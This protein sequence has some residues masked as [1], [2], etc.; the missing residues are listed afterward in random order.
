MHK[1][2][3]LVGIIGLSTFLLA[4]SGCRDD[5]SYSAGG[6]GPNPT[7]PNAPPNT[8]LMANAAFSPI[9]LTVSKNTIVTWTNNDGIVHTATSD[10]GAW[11]T[12][13][14]PPGGS[15]TITFTTTG[16]FR[17]H[18]TYHASMMRGTVVVQ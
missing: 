1:T 15:K 7:P 13:D 6:Y 8:V 11:D 18:C 4:G 10:S 2:L 9:T 12:G 14:I 5:S 17:F 3:H 16:T